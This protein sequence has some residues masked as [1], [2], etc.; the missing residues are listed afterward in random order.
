MSSIFTFDP[1]PPKVLSSP[2]PLPSA[3]PNQDGNM[4]NGEASGIH[5]LPQATSLEGLGIDRLEPEPQ[6]G[7][8]EYKLHLL[9]R[10]RRSFSA[11]STVQQVSGSHLSKSRL[12]RSENGTSTSLPKIPAAPAASNQSRQARLQ[13]L[14]TQLLWRLQQSSPHHAASRSDLV[15]PTLPDSLESMAVPQAPGKLLPGL[16]DS[17][18]ALY[19]IGVADDGTLVGLTNI[20]LDESLRVLHAMASSLGCR[21]RILR[22]IMVGDCQWHEDV[23]ENGKNK[24]KLQTAKLWV[25]EALVCPDLGLD[26]SKRMNGPRPLKIDG[27]ASQDSPVT[28]SGSA[29]AYDG[30]ALR[31]DQL[32]VSLTGSTTSGK[33]SLLGTLSTSTLDNGRGKSRLSLLKHRHEIASGVTSSVTGSLL[34]YRDGLLLDNGVGADSQVINYASGNIS[35]WTDIHSA[36]DPGRLVFLNDSA[37][38]PRFRRTIVRGLVSWAPH[39]TICCIAADN[40]VD[41]SGRP[42]A[43]ASAS[44]VIGSACA[45]IDLAT[46]HLELCL[47]L[48]LSLIVVI[49]KLDLASMGALKPMLGKILSIL[50]SAGRRPEILSCPSGEMSF[51][52]EM[53][54]PNDEREV[55]RLLSGTSVMEACSM[56]PIVLASALNGKGIDK[57]H[58]LLRHL[59]VPQPSTLDNDNDFAHDFPLPG[60][61][62]HIDE[63]FTVRE[64]HHSTPQGSI[65]SSLDSILSG[66]VRH[67]PLVLGQQMLIGPFSTSSAETS[68]PPP[69]V[70]RATSYPKLKG[71]P[72]TNSTRRNLPRPVSGD[73]AV[74]QRSEDPPDPAAVWRRVRIS[75]LRNLRLPVHSLFSDQVGTIGLGFPSPSTIMDIPPLAPQDHIRKGMV[76]LSPPDESSTDAL[77]AYSG[78][79]AHFEANESPPFYPGM[80]VIAYVA[81]VRAPA[82]VFNL[83]ALP[84]GATSLAGHGSSEASSTSGSDINVGTIY[85]FKMTLHFS[86]NREWFELGSQLLVMPASAADVSVSTGNKVD[87]TSV[88]LEGVV[89][90]VVRGLT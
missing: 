40:E 49:T 14:T 23:G 85:R 7:P 47:T 39:W 69:K 13:S 58:A 33:S 56:V 87:K 88:G 46:A 52:T 11:M 67:G 55:L 82:E 38:H 90:R 26:S 34:G 65:E 83:H 30:T 79:V 1:D 89:G 27:I 59:P 73:F 45:E 9:L 16:G 29:N 41:T 10:P 62:F 77:Q 21:V 4:S 8:T 57:L 54:N 50:K 2:W 63:I 66:H 48:D 80:S 32:R 42:G 44:D 81:S 76:L 5:D 70:H 71:S 84:N 3:G 72:K 68:L 22:R 31:T 12:P 43:T 28:P 86:T 78:L 18:G 75:S 53:I 17:Q 25:A 51:D 35:S 20:E 19:E 37:G 61:L 15:V 24:P 64:T 6:D 36:S 60:T 74:T